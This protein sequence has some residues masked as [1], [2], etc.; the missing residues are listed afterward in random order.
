MSIK[1][2][3][4]GNLMPRCCLLCRRFCPVPLCAL[5]AYDDSFPHKR[6]C[7]VC[8]KGKPGMR[9]SSVL[10]D[11]DKAYAGLYFPN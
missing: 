8:R 7:L 2:K 5:G 11:A 3:R 10:P 1:T 4:M 9:C 6:E